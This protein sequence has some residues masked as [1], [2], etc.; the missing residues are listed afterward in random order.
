MNWMP[1]KQFMLAIEIQKKFK[2]CKTQLGVHALRT[3]QIG[4]ASDANYEV[5]NAL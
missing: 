5:V 4:Y 2:H 1:F 3:F